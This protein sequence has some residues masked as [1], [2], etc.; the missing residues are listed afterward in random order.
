M[1]RAAGHYLQRVYDLSVPAQRAFPE[2]R[3]VARYYELPYRLHP[4]ARR[5]AVVGAGTGND[6]AAALRSGVP[7][8][9][10]IEIDPAILR[11]G[12]LYHPEHPYDDPRVKAVVNDARSFL[13]STADT[14][15]LIVYGLLDSHTLLS[16][17]SSIRLDSYVY[18]VEALREARARLEPGGV[19]SLSFAVLSPELGRKIYL[20]MR[21]AFDGHPPVSLYVGQGS[22][23]TFAQSKEGTLRLD[24]AVIAGTDFEERNALFADPALQADV[25]TDD[26]PFFYMPQR[27]YPRSYL[28]AVGLILAISLF[29]YSGFLGGGLRRSTL[30]FFFLGAGFMLV[31]TKGSPSWGLRSATPGR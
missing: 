7:R 12:V 26:W 11:L 31:E 19:V 2:R 9:D 13:R 6:V 29:L 23:V 16:H 20:M 21:Q 10:A 27:V 22:A 4:G 14:Y 25:S 8:V 1:I 28:W 17:A 30:P 5:V 24:P 15:D 18:T 3:S